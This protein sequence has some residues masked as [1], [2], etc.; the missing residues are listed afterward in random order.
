[1]EEERQLEEEPQLQEEGLGEQGGSMEEEGLAQVVVRACVPKSGGG[2]RAVER[3]V[4]TL[5]APSEDYGS[6]TWPAATALASLVCAHERC[7][8]SKS[9]VEIGAGSGLPGLCAAMAGASV[10]MSDAAH[11]RDVLDRLRDAILAN[12]LQRQ[13]YVQGW[14]WGHPL[15]AE[16]RKRPF[17]VLLS[18][19]C[20]YENND[21]EPILASLDMLFR[22]NP[23]MIAII[24]YHVRSSNRSIYGLLSRWHLKAVTLVPQYEAPASTFAEIQLIA[25]CSHSCPPE[26]LTHLLPH[27]HVTQDMVLPC[28]LAGAQ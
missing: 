12:G 7:F 20:F 6:F 8:A 16:L 26:L 3:R 21:F 18:S 25:L 1:M 27:C 28:G 15:P 2:V 23:H 5:P 11:A 17:D 4:W 10:V 9:V 22:L 14:T 19:D 24:S 13:C